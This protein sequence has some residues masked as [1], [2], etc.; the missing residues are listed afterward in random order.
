M[1]RILHVEDLPSDAYLVRREIKKTLEDF[2]IRIVEEKQEFLDALA[3]FRPHVV[4]SD[5]SLPGF[6]WHTALMITRE[7]SPQTPFI[8]VTGSDS[9]EI[10]NMCM[11]AGVTAYINKS[12][13]QELGPAMRS[14]LNAG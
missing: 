13:I 1:Y 12:R 11:Q 5:F 8:I 9:D 3:D 14:V 7:K 6:D 10:R 4:I 2:E